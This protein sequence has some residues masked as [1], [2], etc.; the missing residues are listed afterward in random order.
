MH[1]HVE[2]ILKKISYIEMDMELHRQILVSIPSDQKDEMHTVIQT[3]ADQKK[4]VHDLRLEIK[5]LDESAYNRILAIEKGTEAFKALAREKRFVRV[6][7]PDD[8]GT[9]RITLNDGTGLACL[10]AAQEENGNWMVL[11][12][13]GS[14]RQF[15]K[16]LVKQ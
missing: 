11:T 14:V 3:I 7:T 2:N 8:T 10:V 1:P 5:R 6:K 13:D 15:P 4:Q 12:C 16:G 9:C